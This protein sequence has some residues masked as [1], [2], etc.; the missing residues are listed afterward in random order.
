[1]KKALMLFGLSACLFILFI[2]IIVSTNK[3]SPS[4]SSKI[5]DKAYL[6]HE[7]GSVIVSLNKE[8]RKEFV[9]AAYAKDT[10]GVGALFVAGKI[11]DIK[12]NTQILIIDTDLYNAKV[13]ILDGEQIG[14]SGWVPYEHLTTNKP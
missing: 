7:S 13:R 2:F 14:L 4:A 8:S 1:M 10:L 11:F 6:Y 12:N 9:D 3:K 5:G